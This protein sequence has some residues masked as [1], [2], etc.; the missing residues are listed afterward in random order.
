MYSRAIFLF[1]HACTLK[2]IHNT[3]NAEEREKKKKEKEEEDDPAYVRAHPC[4][5]LN[6]LRL[7]V[8]HRAP[9]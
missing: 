5:L 3:Y 9:G 1:R 2:E 8:D 4:R 6:K 7:F